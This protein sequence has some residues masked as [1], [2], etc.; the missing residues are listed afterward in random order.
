MNRFLDTRG[1]SVLAVAICDRC[2]TKVAHSALSRDP[3]TSLMCCEG[4][5]DFP[6]PYR[7]PQRQP[8]RIALSFARPDENIAHPTPEF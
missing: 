8:D 1:N 7:Q 3:E 4:C 2:S 5:I 6:D